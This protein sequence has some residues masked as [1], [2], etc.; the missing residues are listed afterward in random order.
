MPCTETTGLVSAVHRAA[1]HDGPGLRTTVFMQGCPLRCAWC[2]NPETWSMWP[3]LRFKGADCLACG[4]CVTACA[5]GCQSLTGNERVVDFARCDATGACVD[6]CPSGALSLSGNDMTVA[7]VTELLERDRVSM[8]HS[9]GGV[10]VSGGEPL[11]QPAFSCEV[12]TRAQAVG[13][14]TCCDTSGHVA[15]G[16]IAAAVPVVD[17]WLLDWKASASQHQE[18]TG[19]DRR[20][21][22]RSFELLC[23]AGAA[24]WLRCPLVPGLND[25]AEHFD[26][27]AVRAREPSVQR[28]CLMPYHRHGSAKAVETGLSILDRPSATAEDAA[29]WRDELLARGCGKLAA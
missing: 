2:H 7:E 25:S 29:R 28:V 10:T 22:E 23:S 16:A 13:I 3:Q 1:L 15:A 12:F 24:V 26:D 20:R 14:H 18:L 8:Q 4:A 19:V 11:A 6:V 21:V 9:G 5:T 27:I 17:L